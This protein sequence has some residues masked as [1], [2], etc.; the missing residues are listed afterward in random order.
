MNMP[1]YEGLRLKFLGIW[2]K[3]LANWRKKGLKNEDFT[4]ISNNC[5]GGMIYESYNLP[6]E[7]PTVGLFFMADDY[8]KFLSHLREYLSAE[9]VFITPSE[10]RWKN[11]ITANGDKRNDTYPIGKLEIITRGT[12]S[13]EVFF[14]HYHSEQEA[15]EKWER[16]ISRINWDRLLVKFNDQNGCTAEHIKA[17]DELPYNNKI[18]FTVKEYPQYKSVVRVKAPKGHE[19]IRAS[20]EPFGKSKFIDVTKL[21]NHIT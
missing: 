8:L 6:K 2:R 14:L 18:C 15:K 5:W 13:I 20:Y 4:I 7:S 17:F 1:T 16:R 21:I 11:S 12:E 9:L 19:F 10:S 3:A